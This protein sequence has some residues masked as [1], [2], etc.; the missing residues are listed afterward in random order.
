MEAVLARALKGVA[1]KPQEKRTF[2]TLLVA[3]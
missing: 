2:E 3:S 1:S